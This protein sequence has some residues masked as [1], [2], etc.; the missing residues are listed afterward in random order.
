M[1]RSAI[2]L[3]L[4]LLFT[5]VHANA[6]IVCAIPGV[7][8]SSASNSLDGGSSG[9][10]GGSVAII[11]YGGASIFLI[12]GGGAGI[13]YVDGGGGSSA[14]PGG[15]AGGGGGRTGGGGSAAAGG[16][17][18]LPS[19]MPSRAFLGPHDIPPRQFAAYGIVAFP[20]RSTPQTER[21][22]LSICQAFLASLPDTSEINIPPSDQMVTVWPVDSETVVTELSYGTVGSICQLAV[23]RYHLPSALL[24]LREART[25]SS[26]NLSGDGPYLL[27]WA[28]SSEK[29][30]SSAIVLIY[31]LSN[32]VTPEQYAA[33]FRAWRNDIERK[34][35]LWRHGWSVADLRSAIR[36]WADRWG[37]LFLSIG[38]AK[39]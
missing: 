5:S 13:A 21:R 3:S 32:N 19:V 37:S 2:F 36:N 29:G 1:A 28:P 39:E 27:A 8:C 15:G 22:H 35:E 17:S 10:R 14:R 31:D 9:G 12:A 7:A 16:W 11:G 38:Q 33:S 24:A 20:Q 23:A 26:V 4:I 25:D 34:P 6:L 18:E 30:K